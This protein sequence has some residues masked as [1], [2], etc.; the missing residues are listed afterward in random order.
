MNKMRA[1]VPALILLAGTGS[2]LQTRSQDAMPTLAP[3]RS[4]LPQF[5]GYRASDQVL[6]KEEIEIAGMT[7]YAA[8]AYRRDSVVA[9]TTLVS[10][11]DRQTQGRT[12]HSPRNCL[13]G[14]GWEVLSSRHRERSWSEARVTSSTTTY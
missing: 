3:V 10:Y 7:D 8:R 12:I 1:F 6:S 14:A 2:I 9:F 13:P 11:Y 4:V 5:D